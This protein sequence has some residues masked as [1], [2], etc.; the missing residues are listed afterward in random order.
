[1]GDGAG[2]EIGEDVQKHAGVEVRQYTLY[3]FKFQV[4]DM[5]GV[6]ILTLSVECM[7]KSGAVGLTS[8]HKNRHIQTKNL[9]GCV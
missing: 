8:Q 1:M 4:C 6:I 5:S 7:F 2:G 3:V 9:S